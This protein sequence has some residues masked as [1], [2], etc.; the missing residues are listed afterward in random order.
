MGKEGADDPLHSAEAAV[1]SVMHTLTYVDVI[2]QND[3][4]VRELVLYLPTS[5]ALH[6]ILHHLHAFFPFQKNPPVHLR[7]QHGEDLNK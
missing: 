5:K 7:R 1:H 4:P 6:L 2:I 3:A